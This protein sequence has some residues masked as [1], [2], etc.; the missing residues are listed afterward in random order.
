MKKKLFLLIAAFGFVT[1]G[2]SQQKIDGEA[3]VEQSAKRQTEMMK[4]RFDL[5]DEQEKQIYDI[6]LEFAQKQVEHVKQFREMNEAKRE[7]IQSVLTP[8]QIEKYKAAAADKSGKKREDF[9]KG[10]MNEGKNSDGNKKECKKKEE[11]KD[12][13]KD[14]NKDNK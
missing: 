7:K 4:K 6:N 3:S 8:E 5:T 11:G 13:N 14:D 10:R 12:D 1:F 9:R 2:F